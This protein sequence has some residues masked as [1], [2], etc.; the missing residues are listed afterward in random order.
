M[1]DKRPGFLE[2]KLEPGAPTTGD[3][4]FVL[5]LLPYEETTT[6]RKGTARA[7]EAIVDASG[8][9]E[10]FDETYRIDASRHG[11][12]TI[13]PRI[14]DLASVTAH[15]RSVRERYPAALPGFIGGEH[16]LTPAIIEGVAEE[17]M[18]IVWLD[19]HAD[20]RS[21]FY[22]RADNHACAGYNSRRFG[23]IVQIGVRALAEEEWELIESDDRVRTFMRWGDAARE[24]VRGLPDAVYLSVDFDGFAPEVIRAVGTPEPGGLYWDEVMEI[25]DL[26]FS[27]KRVIAFDAVELCPVEGDHAS[28]FIAARL[29]YKILT[30]HARY[31]L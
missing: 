20:M 11:V 18:G 24:A 30:M 6:Y 16:S 29:V 13:R 2:D 19:A 5:S 27:S 31:G 15:A 26:V 10:L 23:P 7:P 9:V 3:D 12:V 21:S 28:D 8:H 22:G 1:G 4:R 17:G 14:T 25:L